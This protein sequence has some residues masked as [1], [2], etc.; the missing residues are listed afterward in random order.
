MTLIWG[1][2]GLLFKV[3][4]IPL[5]ILNVAVIVVWS[6]P[7]LLEQLLNYLDEKLYYYEVRSFLLMKEERQ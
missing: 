2:L 4:R 5:D 3:A 7:M 6:L 1:L